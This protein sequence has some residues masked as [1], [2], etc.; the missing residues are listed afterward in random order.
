M[1]ARPVAL[2]ASLSVGWMGLV[3]TLV[4]AG[5]GVTLTLSWQPV[6]GATGAEVTSC[7]AS[8]TPAAVDETLGPFTASSSGKSRVVTLPK[9]SAVRRLVLSGLR[10]AVPDGWRDVRSAADLDGDNRLV[11][12]V[13]TG[14][15]FGPPLY[16]VPALPGHPLQP[17][18]LAGASVTAGQSATLALPD[19]PATRV[20]L[21]VVDGDAPESFSEWDIQLG[22]VSVVVAVPPADLV[23]T[24]PDGA[25]VWSMPG[26]VPAS[27]PRVAVD[28]RVAA[29][30]AFTEAVSN[31]TPP[32]ATFTLKGRKGSHVYLSGPTA[33]GSLLR[34]FDGVLTTVV[35]GGPAPLAG[36]SALASEKPASATADLT[37][38]YDGLRLLALSDPVPA[39]LASVA[40]P[41]VSATGDA[42]C[43]AF[44]PAGF[45]AAPL[46]RVGLVG[47]A[48]ED[49]S[50]SVTVVAY[51]GGEPG[52]P[53]GPP[54]V[55]DVVAGSLLGVVWADLP[56]P[57]A[58]T[59][60]P[61]AL[62][63]R[64]TAGTFLWAAGAQPLV[65]LAVRDEDPAPAALTLNG[66]TLATVGRDGLHVPATS[67]PAAS[68]AGATP[69]LGCPL[70]VSVD[71]SD[72]VLRYAR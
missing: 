4:D 41:V 14:G 59:G 65:R 62:C 6:A 22:D 28:L 5:A 69:V 11:V 26:E 7:A 29:E 51:D 43:R 24:G 71:L 12:G 39:P 19:V 18:L 9:Q 31:G 27:A 17:P 20:R 54:G 49:A 72:L 46:A 67:L 36:V 44:P 3:G 48:S 64:A 30:A 56:E 8:V 2:Q 10:R 47:R 38:R 40:G 63:V 23:V 37:V 33:R 58:S 21:S 32:A 53:L 50:L 52:E 70:F 1:T 13:A 68:F 55:V 25:T 15:D 35:A 66:A 45:G 60:T 57:V 61:L 42:V 34:S 16:A